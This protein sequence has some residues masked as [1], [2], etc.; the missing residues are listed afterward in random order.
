MLLKN[1]AR[2]VSASVGDRIVNT[3]A[4]VAGC[5]LI[6]WLLD[7][8]LGS[9]L[10]TEI[11]LLGSLAV[12]LLYGYVPAIA[13][14]VTGWL[15]GLFYFVEPQGQISPVSAFD[16][17]VTADSF[18]MGLTGIVVLEYLQRTRYSMRLMLMVS[19]SRYR[20]LL[21]LDN[22]RIH[23]QRQSTRALRQ[24]GGMFAHLDRVLILFDQ[25][26]KPWLQPLFVEL[27]GVPLTHCSAG[28]WLALIHADD[29]QRVEKDIATVVEG[30]REFRDIRF[31]LAGSGNQ[32]RD[33]SCVCRSLVLSAHQRVFAL[34]LKEPEAA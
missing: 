13:S 20:S 29:R 8:F 7:G 21:K 30:L 14:L 22:H 11:F 17:I 25:Q 4:I 15:I 26:H 2:W 34:V 5:Y 9:Y 12:A 32:Y 1:S 31:R 18:V 16:M 19:E 24:I 28:D 23:Q 6:R 27:T 33:M 3:C 10:P